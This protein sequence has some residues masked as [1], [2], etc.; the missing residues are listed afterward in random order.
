LPLSR[1]VRATA[2][3]LLLSAA[4]AACSARANTP[5]A[6]ATSTESPAAAATAAAVAA[7]PSPAG[8]SSISPTAAQ[9]VAAA[10]DNDDWMLPG[11]NYEN[12]RYTGLAQVTPSNVKSLAKA[13]TTAI[14]DDGQQ[15]TSPIV[16]HGT[17]YL[18]TP[19]ESV[20]ALDAKTGKL[21]WQFPYNPSYVLLY[22]VNRGAG[23]ADGKIFLATQDCRVIALDATTGKQAWNVNGCPVTPY[24][25]TANTWFSIA[26]YVYENKVVLGTAGGD[27]GS[28]GHVMAFSTH[29]GHKLWDWQTVAGPG[30]PGHETWPGNSW[31]HGG[32]PVWSG[33]TIDPKTQTLFIAPGNAGPDM[34]AT[35]RMGK[36]LYTDSLVAL[37][38]SGAQPKL[39]WYYQLMQN[40]THDADPSMPP[41][42]FD[43]K[44]GSSTRHLVAIGDKAADF[45]ILDRTSG[46]VV[47]RLAVD[48]Q[49]GIFTTHP[50]LTGTFAC[51]NHGGGIEY[52]GGAY[53]PGSNL[54]L[55]PSTDECATW[56]LLSTDPQYIPGQPYEG[57][58][59]PKRQR[60]TGK[61][62]AID[63]ATGKVAWVHPFPYPGQGGVLVTKT[64][65]AFTSD[66]GGHLYGFEAKSG[67]V[68]WQTD[69]G[70]ANVAPISAYG[71]DGQEYITLVSGQAGNQHTPNLPPAHGSVVTAYRLGPVESA[72]TNT[73]AGQV[74]LAP[75]NTANLP[76]S[77]GTAPYT[78]QQVT[79]GAQAYAQSCASCHGAHLEGVSAPAL[80]GA[81][82]ASAHLNLAQIRTVVTTQMPLTAPGSLKPEQYADIM[83]FLLSYDCVKASPGNA[84]FPTSADPAFS[85]VVFGGQS[86]PAKAA[87]H[88]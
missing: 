17:M 27:T 78:Q 41:V 66:A 75:R 10:S 60:A 8:D 65:L 44:V 84:A 28:I 5:Q 4:L 47:Y 51:P 72:Y 69:T 86:C 73:S 80:T 12:N 14:A 87:G 63:L 22:A 20:L 7:A 39:R 54:F 42:V 30:Q 57:G 50:T 62:T 49:T 2:V 31:Q 40:D 32:A 18:T 79:A 21:K 76:P 45:V 61:L 77:I 59:L 16:W 23:I 68:L 38:I 83:A 67:K 15:E 36:A 35:R 13:W 64:G 37:D 70:S 33:L 24:T 88:E 55:I 82:F 53:D 19:H 9:L 48:N 56:K 11:K 81:S 71:I 52:N 6:T 26:A 34:V 74:A 46:K 1:I 85:K 3:A 43:G 58:A 25:S 29:D